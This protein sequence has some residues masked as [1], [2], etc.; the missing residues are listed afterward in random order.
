[1]N[2]YCQPYQ[3]TSQTRVSSTEYYILTFTEFD[4][5][6]Y[7]YV[8]CLY[9]NKTEVFMP[10]ANSNVF[11]IY[12]IFMTVIIYAYNLRPISYYINY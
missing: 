12:F 11:K 2:I 6:V 3:P 5:I 7:L 9:I 10:T 4:N 8:Y 1:M